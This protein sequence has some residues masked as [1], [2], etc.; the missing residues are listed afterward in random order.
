VL[1]YLFTSCVSYFQK[2]S[3]QAKWAKAQ[4]DARK[5]AHNTANAILEDENPGWISLHDYEFL[6]P[7]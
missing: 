4:I 7:L 2:Q 3:A 6:L 5:M 1:Y